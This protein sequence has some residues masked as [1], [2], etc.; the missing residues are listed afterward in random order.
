[1]AEQNPMATVEEF[2]KRAQK[3]GE[4]E[5]LAQLGK[6]ASAFLDEVQEW[7]MRAWLSGQLTASLKDGLTA[8]VEGLQETLKKESK[9]QRQLRNNTRFQCAGNNARVFIGFCKK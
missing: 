2:A 4:I 1:M 7:F 8:A 5:D 6:E 3:I 9:K